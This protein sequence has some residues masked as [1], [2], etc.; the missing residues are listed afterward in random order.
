LDFRDDLAWNLVILGKAHS[1]GEENNKARKCFDEAIRQYTDLTTGNDESE[2]LDDLARAYFARSDFLLINCNDPK[3]SSNDRK[4]A[5]L[6]FV[7]LVEQQGKTWYARELA[8]S[9]DT[10]A[11]LAHGSMTKL[12]EEGKE[13]RA[14][15]E[16]LRRRYLEHGAH[17]VSLSLIKEQDSLQGLKQQ[18]RNAQHELDKLLSDEKTQC[19]TT[20]HPSNPPS[21]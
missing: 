3:S 12:K 13:D 10:V 21:E 7:K 14:I 4:K 9:Y 18:I 8:E 5:N 1:S 17:S 2:Y 16:I 19:T 11:E 20:S 15:Y 6:I